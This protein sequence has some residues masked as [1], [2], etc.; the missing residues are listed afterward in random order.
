VL[1]CQV[2]L[3]AVEVVRLSLGDSGWR[4]GEMV[5][6]GKGGRT[7]RLRLNYSLRS[8]TPASRTSGDLRYAVALA[9]STMTFATLCGCVIIDKWPALT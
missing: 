9:A 7:D 4:A 1:T 3:R 2:G 8:T 6:H 5:V